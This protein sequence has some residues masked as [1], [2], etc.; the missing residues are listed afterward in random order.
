MNVF[1]WNISF[2]FHCFTREGTAVSSGAPQS[3][4][5]LFTP[6]EENGFK[7]PSPL[8]PQGWG[9]RQAVMLS[10]RRKVAGRIRTHTESISIEPLSSCARMSQDDPVVL[11]RENYEV[12]L[13]GPAQQTFICIAVYSSNWRGLSAHTVTGCVQPVC[14]VMTDCC[15]S[16]RRRH[17]GE[18]AHHNTR[19]IEIARER[20]EAE[21]EVRYITRMKGRDLLKASFSLRMY[22]LDSFTWMISVLFCPSLFL[23]YAT[24]Y[25]KTQEEKKKKKHTFLL[26]FSLSRQRERG[27]R[28]RQ[29][30]PTGEREGRKFIVACW[31]SHC[32][33]KVSERAEPLKGCVLQQ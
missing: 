16:L 23:L 7:A 30:A 33:T 15:W 25:W 28:R 11:W 24:V 29:I 32:S 20:G 1:M 17:R 22:L 14:P 26:H 12:N 13:T 27:R 4:V 8:A 6:S 18:L 5:S 19:Q 21:G 3:C 9:R 10:L 31:K 2:E